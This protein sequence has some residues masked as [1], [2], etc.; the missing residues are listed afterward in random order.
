MSQRRSIVPCGF[1]TV[2]GRV[3]TRRKGLLLWWWWYWCRNRLETDQVVAW[4]RRVVDGGNYFVADGALVD[5]RQELST[6][7][8]LLSPGQQSCVRVV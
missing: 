7:S 3:G 2:G 8:G 6:L 5:A 1:Y 4:T